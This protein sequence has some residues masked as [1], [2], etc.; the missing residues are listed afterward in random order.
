M[1]RFGKT[2]VALVFSLLHVHTTDLFAQTSDCATFKSDI[3]RKTSTLKTG[4]E[5]MQRDHRVLLG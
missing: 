5:Q 1:F 4:R 2:A 3:V